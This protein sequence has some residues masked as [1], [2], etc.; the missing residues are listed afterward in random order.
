MEPSIP[1]LTGRIAAGDPDAFAVFYRR[2]FDF[3]F[4]EAR[5]ATGRDESFCLDVVHDAMMRVI[6]SMKSMPNEPA[7]R[8]W[9]RSAV[10]SCAYDRLRA[11]ARRRRRE[12]RVAARADAPSPAA[13]VDRDLVDRLAWLRRELATLDE[14]TSAIV[15][16]R[17]RFGW[18][19]EQIGAAV[20]LSPGAVD[21]RLRRALAALTRRAKER[22]DDRA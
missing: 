13:P 19:L 15:T 5:R 22:T 6:R 17:H 4:G 11:E 16:M 3:A 7:L 21:G 12:T 20:G 2:W 1:E 8:S 10:R 9:L 14:S 18:T